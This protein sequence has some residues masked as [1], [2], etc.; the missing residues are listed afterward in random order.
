M[1]GGSEGEGDGVFRAGEAN[2]DWNGVFFAGD[3]DRLGIG[4]F[5]AGEGN[6][7]GG[8][9]DGDEDGDGAIFGFELSLVFFKSSTRRIL[10][11]NDIFFVSQ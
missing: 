6:G 3:G 7:E 5:L 8:F 4:V 10:V 2:C 9:V 1:A 11:P